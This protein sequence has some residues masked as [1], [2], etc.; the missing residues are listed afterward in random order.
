[1]EWEELVDIS[2]RLS[3]KDIKRLIDLN[4]NRIFIYSPEKST[5]YSIDDEAPA[6]LNGNQVQI[7]L[8]RE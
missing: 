2:N 8:E 3:N 5:C 4:H 1:M 7:N 6:C